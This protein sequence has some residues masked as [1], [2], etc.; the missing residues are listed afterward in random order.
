MFTVIGVFDKMKQPFGGGDNPEDN[1]ASFRIGTFMKL[2]PEDAVKVGMWVS[3]KYDDPT[4]APG[5]RRSARAA[6]HPPQGARLAA[7]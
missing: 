7:G 2:H 6:P 4:T 5:G 1:E 3:V